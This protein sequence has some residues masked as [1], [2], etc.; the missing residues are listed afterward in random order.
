MTELITL[1]DLV[2][3]KRLKEG[4]WISRVILEERNYK[5][6]ISKSGC[7]EEQNF[8]I[9]AGTKIFSRFIKV[10]K[11][12]ME[13]VGEVTD[14]TVSYKGIKAFQ[15]G[16]EQLN[17]LC[18]A[19]RSDL[20]SGIVS[21]S[22]N[23][24]RYHKLY[25]TRKKMEDSSRKISKTEKIEELDKEYWIATSVVSKIPMSF[26]LKFVKKGGIER[27]YTYQ[28][29]ERNTSFEYASNVCPWDI[30]GIDNSAIKVRINNEKEAGETKE[31]AYEIVLDKPKGVE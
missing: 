16:A 14:F 7:E 13:C 1:K 25:N 3:S 15:N 28:I 11:G 20:A 27:Y 9:K 10:E 12:I 30:F 19:L 26:G 4:D 17:W 21:Y 8:S 5:I 23:E 31:S 29:G 18:N 22:I 2:E 24:E 6:L